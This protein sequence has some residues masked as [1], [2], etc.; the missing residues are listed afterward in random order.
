MPNTGDG[1]PLALGEI[2]SRSDPR[3]WHQLW[4][5]RLITRCCQ[6]TSS[7]AARGGAMRHLSE[8]FVDLPLRTESI[9]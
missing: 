2:H 7:G 5:R 9:P 4:R 8:R 6:Q 1:W 3:S